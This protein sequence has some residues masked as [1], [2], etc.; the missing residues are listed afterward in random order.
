[1]ENQSEN[2]PRL[3]ENRSEDGPRPTENRSEDGPRPTE[4]R[5]EDGPRPTENRSED[6]PRPT[7]NRSEQWWP[8]AQGHIGM[9]PEPQNTVRSEPWGSTWAASPEQRR[10]KA[11]QQHTGRSPRS[12]MQEA[13]P[14]RR[15]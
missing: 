1:M 3:T 4:N 10:E 9:P 15:P 8:C 12:S 2:G 5:S 13:S 11:L 7:E 6:G 14:G